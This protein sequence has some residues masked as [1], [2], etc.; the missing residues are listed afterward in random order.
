MGTPIVLTSAFLVIA[1]VGPAPAQDQGPDVAPTG[2]TT[3]SN[4][5]LSAMPS[6]QGPA[7]AWNS[8]EDVVIDEAICRDRIH[9]ARE[10]M[11]QPEL[12][13]EPATG[14]E[15]MAIWAVDRRE[16]GCS[17]LVAMGDPEDIRPIPEIEE[18]FGLRPA[19]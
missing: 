6:Y 14:D 11:G 18:Q 5:P 15:A 16:D 19:K 2:A 13:R 10:Q 1:A 17:V 4:H 12:D 3:T 7:V 9:E 8:Y